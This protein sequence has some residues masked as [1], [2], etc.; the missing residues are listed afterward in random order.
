MT[1][2]ADQGFLDL[3]NMRLEYRMVGPRP[4]AAPT[5]VLLHEGLGSVAVWNSFPEELASATGAG[6]FSYS[7]AGYGRSSPSEL[8]RPVSFMH[9]EAIEVLPRV[10]DAM[11]FRRGLLIGHSDG[12]SIA[13][14]YAGSVQDHRVRGLALMAPHFFTEDMGIAEIA[15]AKVEFETGSLRA[16]LARLHA[17]PDN[18]FYNWN[19]PSDRAGRE[20]PVRHRAADRDRAAGVLLPGRS[21]AVAGHTSRAVSRGAGC[22]A[23]R[24]RRFRQPPAARPRRRQRCR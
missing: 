9:D 18:A 16:K 21:R 14:I 2:L 4:D 10:L 13:A 6:V 20:R 22:D 23:R 19:G 7:R 17:D 3:G 8:P 12:A 5:L 11:G 15:R 1:E 24:H